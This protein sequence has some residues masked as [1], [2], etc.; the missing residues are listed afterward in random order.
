MI[1]LFVIPRG[2]TGGTLVATMLNAHPDLSMGYEVFPDRMVDA[3]GKAYLANELLETVFNQEPGTDIDNSEFAASLTDNFGVFLMRAFRSGIKPSW[4]KEHLSEFASENRVFDEV[5]D[6]LDFIDVLLQ[7]QMRETGKSKIG[8]KM[9]V[10]PQ[11]LH[12]RNPNAVFIMMVRD[13]RDVLDSRLNVGSFNQTPT[14]CANDWIQSLEE[15]ER[16]RSQEG[17]TAHFVLY[18]KLVENPRSQLE[19]V[20]NDIGLE[21][22]DRVTNYL[23]APQELFDHSFGHLSGKQIEKGLNSNSIGRWKKGLNDEQANEFMGIAGN[24]MKKFGYE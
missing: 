18:E 22:N 19:A 21:W 10:D 14:I 1:D 9:R 16:F 11:L 24:T 17:V 2:R 23:D 20:L 15:F 12:T 5:E 4:I 8:A 6:R 13:G 7:R 3:E